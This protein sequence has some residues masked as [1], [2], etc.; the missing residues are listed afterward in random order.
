MSA[1]ELLLL[2]VAVWGVYRLLRPLQRRIEAFLLSRL[3]GRAAIVEAEIVRI[4]KNR[5]KE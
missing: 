1:A 4:M 5:N 3:T 2:T